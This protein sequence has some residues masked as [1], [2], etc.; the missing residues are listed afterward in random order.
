MS[1]SAGSFKIVVCVRWVPDFTQN[2]LEL[3][4]VKGQL[5]EETLHY[6][7]NDYDLLAVEEA[8]RI[9]ET[10]SFP[11]EVTVISFGPEFV[12]EI[13]RVCLA[14]GADRAI[15]VQ[16]NGAKEWKGLAVAAIL[17]KAIEPLAYDLIL[18]GQQ[19]LTGM[20]S[21]VGAGVAHFLHL[22]LIMGIVKLEVSLVR[23]SLQATQKLEKGDRWVWE[24]PLPAVCTVEKGTNVPRYISIHRLLLHRRRPVADIDIAEQAKIAEEVASCY[25]RRDL[26]GIAYPRIRPKKTAAPTVSLSPA[27]RL[28]FLKS[29]GSLEEKKIERLKGNPNSIAHQLV[30]FLTEKGFV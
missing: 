4:T 7:A 30:Q 2:P 25:G 1:M 9:R 27:E 24:C 21:I 23:R 29:G 19:S 6:V 5:K 26:Q 13:L 12:K 16:Q 10:L 8:I 28:R 22:P 18:C 15:H 11:C 20:H 3:D 14:M 17:A